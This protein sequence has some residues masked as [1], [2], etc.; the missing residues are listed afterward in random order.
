LAF[1]AGR[2]RDRA[3]GPFQV[4]IVREREYGGF[5]HLTPLPGAS[6]VELGSAAKIE[7]PRT[8]PSGKYLLVRQKKRRKINRNGVAASSFQDADQ[9]E[10]YKR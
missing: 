8:K 7:L 10:S 5:C 3:A 9:S 6:P 2:K 1:S 4:V